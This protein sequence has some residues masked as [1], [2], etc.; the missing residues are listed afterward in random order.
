MRHALRAAY[1][2]R[3]EIHHDAEP[4]ARRSV[5]QDRRDRPAVLINVTPLVDV[6]LVLLILFMV[7]AP[8]ITPTKTTVPLPATNH[9]APLGQDPEVLPLVVLADGA[10]LLDGV[11]VAAD[12]LE[13]RL[14]VAKA[15][16]P[17]AILR[18]FA[19]ERVRYREVRS[20][21]GIAQRAGFEG[22]ELATERREP[23]AGAGGS[24]AAPSQRTPGGSQPSAGTK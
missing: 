1:A 13:A 7:V 11:A 10:L 21:M 17:R 24:P 2:A 9:P 18:I 12:R 6:C 14:A 23:A 16:H 22:V 19:D 3:A 20:A 5:G 4:Q 15:A 8:L